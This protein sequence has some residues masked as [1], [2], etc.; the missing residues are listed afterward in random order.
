[1]LCPITGN[2]TCTEVPDPLTEVI[3]ILPHFRQRFPEAERAIANRY[4]QI[5]SRKAGFKIL[6]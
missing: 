2:L 1:M 6:L 4:F 5:V 3:E